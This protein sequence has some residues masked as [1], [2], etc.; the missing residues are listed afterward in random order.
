MEI[1]ILKN[2]LDRRNKGE[3]KFR[4]LAR[5]SER[6]SREQAQRI[7][8]YEKR[9]ESRESNFLFTGRPISIE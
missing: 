1:A 7:S 2:F 5:P 9:K 8:T 6:F 3:D 4:P